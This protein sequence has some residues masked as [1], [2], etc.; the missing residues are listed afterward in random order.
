MTTLPQTGPPAWLHTYRRHLIWV[1]GAAFALIVLAWVVPVSNPADAAN[2]SDRPLSDAPRTPPR[3]DLTAFLDVNRWG[4]SLREINDRI[5]QEAS[6]D[7]RA[8]LNPA[9]KALGYVGLVVEAAAN[10]VLLTTTEGTVARLEPGHVLPDGRVL[11]AVEGNSI[12]LRSPE[13]GAMD[14]LELFPRPPAGV[15]SG[16]EAE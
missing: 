7:R 16:K 3:E 5:A 4:I 11:A 10:T 14:V 1:A 12:T 2:A 13:T 15:E 6:Q 8:G 9:L